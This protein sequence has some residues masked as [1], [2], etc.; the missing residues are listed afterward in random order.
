MKWLTSSAVA[1]L[2]A[3][4]APSFAQ[5]EAIVPGPEPAGVAGRTKTVWLILTGYR[6]NAAI[7]TATI[8]QCELSGAEFMASKRFGIDYKKFECLEGVR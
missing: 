1:A 7:P 8:E 6:F 5:P 2:V 3:A 4:G